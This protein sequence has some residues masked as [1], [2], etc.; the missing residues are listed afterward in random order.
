MS[1]HGDD[2]CN[3]SADDYLAGAMATMPVGA[4]WRAEEGSR[5]R[6]LLR[7]LVQ[8][9]HRLHERLCLLL[10]V[11]LDV[12]RAFEALPDWE[13][14]TGLPDDCATGSADTLQ[15]RR[16]AVVSRLTSRGGQS[17]A[18]FIELA[19]SLGYAVTIT[20]FRP[21]I[22]G[23]SRCG[24]PRWQMGPLSM[25]FYWRVSVA[26]PRVT[27][28]RMGLGRYGQDPH[29]TIARAED[30]ECLFNRHKPA[31]TTLIFDYSGN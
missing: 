12:T 17:R 23:Q 3:L 30:L 14:N 2:Y 26:A 10:Q 13:R 31:H 5:P 29:A 11:E 27:W 24:D 18:F 25:R 19:T 20:E 15:E 7:G 21:F 16:Q 6:Q 1:Q 8:S 22:M 28:F 4:A 9:I